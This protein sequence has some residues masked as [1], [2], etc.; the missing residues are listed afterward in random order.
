MREQTKEFVMKFISTD[1]YMVDN[2][3]SSLQQDFVRAIAIDHKL[4]PLYEKM[5]KNFKDNFSGQSKKLL[6]KMEEYYKKKMDADLKNDK[7]LTNWVSSEKISKI[8]TEFQSA[9]FE[10]FR[11]LY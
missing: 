9:S 3:I 6:I 2:H 10:L 1:S 5:L 11:E 8:A 4:D 7:D